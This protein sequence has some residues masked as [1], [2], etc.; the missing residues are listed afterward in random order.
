VRGAHRDA[1]KDGQQQGGGS[2]RFGTEPV[3]R[4]Q[5]NQLLPHRLDD[6]PAA[7][8]R[9]QPHRRVAGQHHLGRNLLRRRETTSILAG[10]NQQHE[11]NP[12]GLL[13]VVSAVPQTVECRRNKLSTPE[14]LVHLPGTDPM[15]RPKHQQADRDSDR[16]PD[17]WSQ[18]NEDDRLANPLPLQCIPARV[19]E[20]CPDQATDERMRRTRRKAVVPRQQ[21]PKAGADEYCRNDTVVHNIGIDNPLPHGGCNLQVEEQKCDEIEKGCPDDRL[22]WTQDARRDDGGDRIGRVMKAVNIIKG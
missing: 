8:K 19:D 18:K 11:N 12:H 22:H 20:R 14:Q 17:K 6:A 7:R 13:G 5:V 15:Q 9:P 16:H 21:V 1:P 4:A 10:R 2:A 3:D